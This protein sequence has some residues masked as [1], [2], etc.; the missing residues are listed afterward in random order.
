M[1]ASF[2]RREGQWL[3]FNVDD[4]IT[5]R[6]NANDD[7]LD[8]RE[9]GY[10]LNEDGEWASEETAAM[11]SRLQQTLREASACLCSQRN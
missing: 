7:C 3:V 10:L 8:L 4:F 1:T 5:V 11:M 6:Y 2:L 9:W